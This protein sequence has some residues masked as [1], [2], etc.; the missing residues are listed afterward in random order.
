MIK[1][2]M[3][4]SHIDDKR[5]DEKQSYYTLNVFHEI[6]SCVYYKMQGDRHSGKTSLTIEHH[7]EQLNL[8]MD[9]INL[10]TWLGR[11]QTTEL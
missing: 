11:G 2:M 5:N 1:E 9:L 8:V 3:K 7:W 4:S 6:I 10:P